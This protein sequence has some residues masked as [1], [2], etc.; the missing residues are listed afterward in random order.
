LKVNLGPWTAVNTNL[1]VFK[2][3]R[4]P[5][6]KYWIKNWTGSMADFLDYR[7]TISGGV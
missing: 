2:L 6:S 1:Q 3:R 7:V 4:S 5:C